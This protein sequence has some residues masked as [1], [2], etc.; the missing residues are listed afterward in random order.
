MTWEVG[1]RYKRLYKDIKNREVFI[2]VGTILTVEEVY[3]DGDEVLFHEYHARRPTGRC[4]LTLNKD[5]EEL[6]WEKF[7]IKRFE[8]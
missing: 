5:W 8:V 4:Y 2:P 7:F 3:R 1:K 6:P